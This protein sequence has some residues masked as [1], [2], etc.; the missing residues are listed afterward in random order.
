MMQCPSL[1]KGLRCLELPHHAGAHRARGADGAVVTWTDADLAKVFAPK[2]RLCR[3]CGCAMV[4]PV[5]RVDGQTGLVEDLRPELLGEEAT[6]P[7]IE[8]QWVSS[9]RRKRPAAPEITAAS[10]VVGQLEPDEQR[11]VLAELVAVIGGCQLVRPNTPPFWNPATRKMQP[12]RA[13]HVKVSAAGA[14]MWWSDEQGYRYVERHPRGGGLLPA[15]PQRWIEIYRA[16]ATCDADPDSAVINWYEGDG[17]D[18]D[19]G[20]GWHADRTEAEIQE[21]RPDPADIIT[22]SIGWAARWAI[23]EREK[24]PVTRCRLESGAITRL[25][26]PTRLWEHTIEGLLAPPTELGLLPPEAQAEPPFVPYPSP[27][28]RPGRYSITMRRAT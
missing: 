18:P 12:G 6:R 21:S 11:S 10:T 5:C 3:T 14:R 20:L 7:A 16:F 4:C 9:R 2:H 19:M 1:W 23:R 27:L 17:K 26:G 8:M 15:L 28:T 22:I 24:T 25:A 13:M